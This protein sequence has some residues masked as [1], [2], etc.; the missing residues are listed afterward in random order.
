MD[1]SI[2]MAINIK[3]VEVELAVRKLAQQMGV[4]MTHAIGSAVSHELGR[5][6]P[7]RSIRLSSMRAIANRVSELPIKDNRSED[8]ILGYDEAGL[9]R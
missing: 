7:A 3:N 1:W 8:E 6:S 4:D 2:E 9:P 5:I